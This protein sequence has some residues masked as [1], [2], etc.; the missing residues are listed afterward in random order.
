MKKIVITHF[1][2]IYL[3][4][5]EEFPK[6]IEEQLKKLLDS[7][8]ELNPFEIPDEYKEAFEWII[9]N[10]DRGEET[11]GVFDIVY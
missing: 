5:G 11:Y 3:E 9:D 1:N 8:E 4:A 7:G 10:M 2:E 6:G